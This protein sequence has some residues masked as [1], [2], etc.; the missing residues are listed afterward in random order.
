MLGTPGGRG[1]YS[2]HDHFYQIENQPVVWIGRGCLRDLT[3]A[4]PAGWQTDGRLV[5]FLKAK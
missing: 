3:M 5:V 4:F 1:Y 2:G